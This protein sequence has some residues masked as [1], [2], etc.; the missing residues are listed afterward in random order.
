MGILDAFTGNLTPE[1]A[2]GLLGF[3][4]Q[5]LGS[6][7]PSR[8]PTSIGQVFGAGLQGAQQASDAYRQREQQ[9]GQAEQLAAMRALELQNSTQTM[10]DNQAMRS[11][12]QA[13][14]TPDGGFDQAKFIGILSQSNPIEAMRL[15]Q[16]SA[17][18]FSDKVMTAVD[19]VTGQPYQ[20]ILSDTGKE[21][22]LSGLP[23]DELKLANLGGVDMAYNPFGLNAGQ[24]FKRTQSPDSMA[25]TALGWANYGLSKDRLNF[26]KSKEPVGAKMT[27]DQAKATG[28]LVQAENAYKNLKKVAFDKDGKLTGAA[29]PGVADAIAGIPFVGSPIGN[30]LRSADRQ[31]FNQAASSLSEA[32]L[33]A[34]TGAGV[35]REEALQKI[36]EITPVWGEDEETSKQKLASIPL[37]IESLKVRS[38][39]GAPKAAKVISSGALP[40]GWS[41][42][43]NP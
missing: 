5:A 17:D 15:S 22:R 29:R 18:K 33:R 1:Q 26:D 6:S 4:T 7:G 31:K 21:K 11:A 39:P 9:R 35:T 41:V 19:Q 43:E 10:Q 12:A 42:T 16:K 27:E 28:W 13:S 14:Y 3:A 30:T 36:Q 8:M 40:S 32:F 34:A 24:T 23:R 25:S 37:Y 20:Y 2:Q 38:G